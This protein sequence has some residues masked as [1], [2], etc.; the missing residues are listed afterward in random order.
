MFCFASQVNL[1]IFT[2]QCCRNKGE[3]KRGKG[4]I[5]P[6]FEADFEDSSYGFRT[7]RSLKDAITAIRERLKQGKTE[8]YDADLSKYFDTILHDKLQ[9]VLK[10]HITDPRLLKLINK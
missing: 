2:C 9:I 1:L 8:V 7:K 10:Q 5:E 4:K 3:R 6:I